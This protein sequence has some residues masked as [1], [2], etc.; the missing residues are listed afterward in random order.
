MLGVIENKT[1]TYKRELVS[2]FEHYHLEFRD[3]EAIKELIDDWGVLYRGEPKLDKRQIL[4]YQKK[5]KLRTEY[6]A[7]KLLQKKG[8]IK[9]RAPLY[10]QLKNRKV[11]DMI[12]EVQFVAKILYRA[13]LCE[14]VI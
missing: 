14:V 11:G 5:R 10:D 13:E 6:Q 9:L 2:N 12:E 8:R 4:D 3:F 1:G 7:E